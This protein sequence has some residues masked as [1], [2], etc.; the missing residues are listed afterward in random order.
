MRVLS[1]DPGDRSGWALWNDD[2]VLLDTGILEIDDMIRLLA[3]DYFSP[4]STVVYEDYRLNRNKA[5]AQAGSKMAASQVIGAA[6][7]LAARQEAILQAQEVG[8][9]RMASMHSGI[10][11]PSNHRN[12]HHVDAVLHGYWYFEDQG[13]QP[14][15]RPALVHP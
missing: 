8:A 1:L 14:H 12:G 15:I 6:K 3:S 9:M 2:G 10:K 13:I 7:A 11:R 5:L 4:L